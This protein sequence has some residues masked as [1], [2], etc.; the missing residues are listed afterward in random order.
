MAGTTHRQPLRVGENAAPVMMSDLVKATGG[1]GAQI[2]N[3]VSVTQVQY[4]ALGTP[5]PKTLYIISD[6]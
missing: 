4:D 6:A 1:V 5:D 2:V 3:V